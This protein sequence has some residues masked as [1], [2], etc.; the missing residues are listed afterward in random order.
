M[1][2]LGELGFDVKVFTYELLATGNEKALKWKCPRKRNRKRCIAQ[3][4][5]LRAALT[6]L[7]LLQFIARALWQLQDTLR[8]RK[9]CGFIPLRCLSNFYKPGFFPHVATRKKIQWETNSCLLQQM[10]EVLD[11]SAVS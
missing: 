7:E 10:M 6:F 2:F 11:P 1:H 4:P 8:L 9:F 3:L 5:S